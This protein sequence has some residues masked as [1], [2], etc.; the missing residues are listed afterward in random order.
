MPAVCRN[1]SCTVAARRT[2]TSCSSLSAC[3]ATYDAATRTVTMVVAEMLPGTS[4]FLVFDVNVDAAPEVA[5]GTTY[6]WQGDNIGAAMSGQTTTK[7][8]SNVVTVKASKTVLPATGSESGP[9][10]LFGLLAILLGGVLVVLTRRREKH[11]TR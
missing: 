6:S 3:T 9:L 2:G 1:K 5:P 8:P 7:V 4:V 11:T 10:V